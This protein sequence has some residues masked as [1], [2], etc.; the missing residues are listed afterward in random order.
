MSFKMSFKIKKIHSFFVI[1]L[2]NLND[3]NYYNQTKKTSFCEDFR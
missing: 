2:Q 1:L 3:I